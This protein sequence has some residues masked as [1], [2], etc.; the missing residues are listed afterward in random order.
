MGEVISGERKRKQE[1]QQMYKKLLKKK[2]S[3][4]PGPYATMTMWTAINPEKATLIRYDMHLSC[5]S[6]WPGMGSYLQQEATLTQILINET[7]K[8]KTTYR[9]CVSG[10]T[11][12][13]EN[14]T[15]LDGFESEL[16]AKYESVDKLPQWVQDRLAVLMI[17]D[18]DSPPQKEI[19]NIGIRISSE[20]FW[21]FKDNNGELASHG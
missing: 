7:A 9:I 17:L 20:V 5:R 1:A 4:H 3:S 12:T 10:G 6:T 13:T 2:G 21:V 18:P 15:F 14:F 8:G 11:V 19:E 16:D